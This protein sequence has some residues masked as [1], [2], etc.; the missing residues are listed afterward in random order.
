LAG[1]RGFRTLIVESDS[2]VGVLKKADYIKSIYN[3]PYPNHLKSILMDWFL[4]PKPIQLFGYEW[5]NLLD[6]QIL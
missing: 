5:N 4:H 6:F 2:L 1:G 3:C